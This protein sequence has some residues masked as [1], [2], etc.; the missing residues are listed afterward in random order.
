MASAVVCPTAHRG[1]RFLRSFARAKEPKHARFLLKEKA[2]Q[3]ELA[4]E[5]IG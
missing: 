5:K 2:R 3:R 4:V 1:E